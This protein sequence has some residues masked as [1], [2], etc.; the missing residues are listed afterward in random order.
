MKNLLS[1]SLFI[2][3]ISFFGC[4]SDSSTSDVIAK[5]TDKVA[6]PLVEASKTKATQTQTKTNQTLQNLEP[7]KVPSNASKEE[8]QAIN[9]RNSEKANLRNKR[10]KEAAMKSGEYQQQRK[11]AMKNDKIPPCFYL[12]TAKVA[13]VLGATKEEIFMKDATSKKSKYSKACF[14][15]YNKDGDPNGGL[16]FQIQSNPIPDEFD[17]WGSS[18]IEA[19]KT[20][21]EKSF[22]QGAKPFIYKAFNPDGMDGAY[23]ADTKKYFWKLNEDTVL[24]VVFNLVSN[25]KTQLKWATKLAEAVNQKFN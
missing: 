22:E 3:F 21:G 16:M 24:M 8:R 13:E 15:R 17:S 7:E 5:K 1:Y 10:D 14:Y 2:L 23:N 4:K 9:K 11:D 19:K 18:F 12:S 25:E 20:G 6:K